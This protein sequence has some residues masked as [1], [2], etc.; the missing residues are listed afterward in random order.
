M[1]VTVVTWENENCNHV[2][3]NIPLKSANKQRWY[4]SWLVT[5]V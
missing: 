2:L 5:P 3:D 1:T 4:F